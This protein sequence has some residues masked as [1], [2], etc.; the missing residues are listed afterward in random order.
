MS[1]T[2]KNSTKRNPFDYYPTPAWCVH[3]L[4]EKANIPVKPGA[5]WLEPAAGTGAIIKAVG[6]YQY[7]KKNGVTSIVTYKPNWYGVEIQAAFQPELEKEIL[8][9]RVLIEDFTQMSSSAFGITP[10]VIITNPPFNKA[11]EFIKK[12][13]EMEAEYVCMLLRLN[14]LGSAERSTFMR[15]NTP[16]IYVLPNRPSFTGKGTDSIEYAWFVWR[17]ENDYGAA[18]QKPVSDAERCLV[19]SKP[20]KNLTPKLIILGDTTPEE[21]KKS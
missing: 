19:C 9:S 12:G 20:K 16:D 15:E 6:S 11:L 3:R 4:L 1:S 18:I 17:K 5:L 10:Q 14:F 2:K 8:Q 7:I 21:R 13:I